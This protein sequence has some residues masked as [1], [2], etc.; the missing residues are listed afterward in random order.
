MATL[1]TMLEDGDTRVVANAAQALDEIGDPLA[2]PWLEGIS[3]HSNPRIQAHALLGL[4]R[5]GDPQ[6]ESRLEEMTWDDEETRRSSGS[7][8]LAQLDIRR[9]G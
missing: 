3:S 8:A 7:W 6:A 4:C 1:R 2:K 9:Q 5:L